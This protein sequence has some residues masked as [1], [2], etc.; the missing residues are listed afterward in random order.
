[1]EFT[2]V[3]KCFVW[4]I[5]TIGALFGVFHFVNQQLGMDDDNEIEETIEQVIEYHT[6]IDFDLTPNSKE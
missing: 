5:V 4:S 6:D 1:M 3:V 2:V